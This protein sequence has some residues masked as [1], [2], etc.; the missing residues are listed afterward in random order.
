[1]EQIKLTT[2]FITLTQLLKDQN[3]IQTGGQA[4]WFLADENNV[5]IVNDEVENRRG[6]KLYRGDKIIVN[7]TD[8]FEII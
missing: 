2:E 6:R 7:N 5:V 3:L 4:K 1:M 8:K